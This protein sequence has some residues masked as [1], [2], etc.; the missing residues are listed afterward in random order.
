[1]KIRVYSLVLCGF[2]VDF[3][4]PE[5]NQ[6]LLDAYKRRRESADAKVCCDYLLQVCLTDWNDKVAQEMETLVKDNGWCL[7]TFAY[8]GVLIVFQDIFLRVI[9][10]ESC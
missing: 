4:V 6:S 3:V 8:H 10:Y 7:I 1:M 5:V 2:P 9:F